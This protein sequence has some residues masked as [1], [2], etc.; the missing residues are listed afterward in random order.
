MP[1][2]NS[3]EYWEKR[4]ADST[5]KTYNSLEEKNRELLEFYQD[6]SHSIR[7]E[8]Y[9][10]AEKYSKD[11]VLSRTDIYRQNHLENLEKKFEQI[12]LD[13]GKKTDKAVTKNMQEG[14]KSVYGSTA[15]GLGEI[16]YAMPNKALM[17]KL[18][19]EPWR[20]DSFSGRLWKNQKK[21]AVGLNDILLEGLRS[22]K[23]VTEIAI[24]LHNYI[25]NGF[26][27]CHRLVRTET[28][29][30]LNS[31]TLQRYKDSGVEYV[32]VW[33][34]QDERTCDT[35]GVE[36]FHSNVYPVDKCPAMPFHANCRCTI[37]P[38][39]DE[40]LIQEYID[41]NVKGGIIK[42]DKTVSGHTGTPKEFEPGAVIDHI[43]RDNKVDV[44][45]FYGKNGLKEKDIHTTNHG[46]PKQHPYGKDGE[47]AH[48]YEWDSEGRLKSK[49]I[50]ELK[51]DER[52]GNG[53]IL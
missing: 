42:A 21:L 30:Y 13:L 47:H 50:R 48:D 2:K 36:G 25:D 15:V 37:I 38:C 10:L 49:N 33:A 6:A 24:N 35:C 51:D 5:W 43:G 44:R 7:N 18:L 17:E 14:F 40:K 46:N 3:P 9:D 20:G 32:Q 28:M 1:K 16:D 31:A 34:A 39:F 53:D 23:T 41:K 52:K 45:T 12:I 26:N 4:I 22:G 8:L 11:G 29:H 19:N 27:N